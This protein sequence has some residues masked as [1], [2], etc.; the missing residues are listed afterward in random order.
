MLVRNNKAHRTTQPPWWDKQCHD[1][2]RD[3]MSAPHYFRFQNSRGTLK[4]YKMH[5]NR[6]KNVIRQKKGNLFKKKKE[7]LIRSRS[8]PL[9]FWKLIKQARASKRSYDKIK[10]S[11]LLEYFKNLLFDINRED[12]TNFECIDSEFE[13]FQSPITDAEV[14]KRILKLKPGKAGGLTG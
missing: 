10:D 14:R 8:N 3:K 5:K 13:F 12:I 7:E 6:F 4:R 11:E 9:N 1:L 2:K